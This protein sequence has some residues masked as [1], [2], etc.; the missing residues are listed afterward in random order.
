MGEQRRPAGVLLGHTE[1][2]T[3]V[4]ARGDGRYFCSNA[5]DSTIRVWDVRKMASDNASFR[6]SDKA[7]ARCAPRPP[8]FLRSVALLCWRALACVLP[9]VSR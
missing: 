2:I 9:V 3:H 5:K 4:D 1:G 7:R 8:A 6:L